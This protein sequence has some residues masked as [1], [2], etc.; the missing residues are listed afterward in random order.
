MRGSP[1]FLRKLAPLRSL[2]WAHDLWHFRVVSNKEFNCTEAC[3]ST[4]L[5]LPL[6]TE[7]SLPH[8]NCVYPTWYQSI[9]VLATLLLGAFCLLLP[10][11]QAGCWLASWVNFHSRSWL[12]LIKSI[13]GNKHPKLHSTGLQYFLHHPLMWF[14]F[15]L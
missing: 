7:S 13:W 8:D 4:S 2:F 1:I 9:I 6:C 5:H 3:T 12:S 14:S 10:G 15:A 11:C